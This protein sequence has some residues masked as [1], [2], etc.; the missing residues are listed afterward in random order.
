MTDR[1]LQREEGHVVVAGDL[2]GCRRTILRGDILCER[3]VDEAFVRA[4]LLPDPGINSSFEQNRLLVTGNGLH[5]SRED[6]ESS[7]PGARPAG[8]VARKH[9]VC[10]RAGRS[11]MGRRRQQRSTGG[12]RR[13]L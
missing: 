10:R 1:E 7:I 6:G 2:Q 4:T 3:A 12:E 5:V 13:Q 11:C 9:R 8:I